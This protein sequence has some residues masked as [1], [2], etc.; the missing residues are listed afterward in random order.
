[1]K[2]SRSRRFDHVALP[3]A[4]AAGLGAMLL[5]RGETNVQAAM[6]ERGDY[7]VVAGANGQG[8]DQ[9][10]WILDTRAEEL[11]AAGWDNASRAMKGFG[12]RDI[13]QDLALVQQR[14]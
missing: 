11:V 7:L 13:N 4:L 12:T 8:D 3:A 9:V 2:A 14:R 6:Q 1:M 5:L 10:L